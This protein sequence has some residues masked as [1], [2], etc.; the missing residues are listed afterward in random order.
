MER[1]AKD[2]RGPTSSATHL[3]TFRPG[4]KIPLV[5]EAAALEAGCDVLLVKYAA[6]RRHAR[7]RSARIEARL[8]WLEEVVVDPVLVAGMLPLQVTPD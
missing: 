4:L 3:R 2:P 1:V 7:G 8:L 6:S 5:P